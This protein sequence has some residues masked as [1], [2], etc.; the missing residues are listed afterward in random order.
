MDLGSKTQASQRDGQAKSWSLAS[1][2][3]LNEAS[4]LGTLT[5]AEGHGKSAVGNDRVWGK[6]HLC[7]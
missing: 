4:S 3:T 5:S 2:Q 6:R 7:V 1:G